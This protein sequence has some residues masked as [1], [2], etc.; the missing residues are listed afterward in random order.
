MSDS[1]RKN[2][3]LRLALLALCAAG[4]VGGVACFTP[5]AMQQHEAALRN[6]VDLLHPLRD[7]IVG[8]A[9]L[10]PEVERKLGCTNGV[11][12]LGTNHTYL[13]TRGGQQLLDLSKHVDPTR[14]H[15][16][17]P[18]GSLQY[19]KQRLWGVAHVSFEATPEE[20]KGDMFK[21]LRQLGFSRD[22]EKRLVR[23]I[24]V[25]GFIQDPIAVAGATAQKFETV[26][27]VEFYEPVRDVDVG[28]RASYAL[29]KLPLAIVGDTALVAG[30]IVAIPIVGVLILADSIIP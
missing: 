5:D 7:T 6:E 19:K 25:E 18:R 22:G 24:P 13:V 11:A 12:F 26:R 3:L 30:A 21:R 29:V 20:L 14:L 8:A 17:C 2:R 10:A 1:A 27:T 9:T 16:E 28:E 4:V 15:L 23:R